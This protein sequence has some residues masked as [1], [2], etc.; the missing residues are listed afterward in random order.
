[1]RRSG[2]EVGQKHQPVRAAVI[3]VVEQLCGPWNI[4]LPD[5]QGSC[6][7]A[8]FVQRQADERVG[9]R[10]CGGVGD[11]EASDR[12][13]LRCGHAPAAEQDNE[14]CRRKV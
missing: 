14:Q 7:H 9:S 12:V 1:V 5:L 10:K 2:I 11:F 3:V 6:R 4:G 8:E 13:T